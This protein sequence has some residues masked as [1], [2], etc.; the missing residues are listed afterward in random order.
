MILLDL[1]NSK[2]DLAHEYFYNRGCIIQLHVGL[3]R[4]TGLKYLRL[5]LNQE[6]IQIVRLQKQLHFYHKQRR[7]PY[8]NS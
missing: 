8:V 1:L 7:Y 3:A 5:W 6:V 4:N 2:S